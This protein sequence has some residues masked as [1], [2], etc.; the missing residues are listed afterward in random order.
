[1]EVDF[2]QKYNKRYVCNLLPDSTRFRIF[3][4]GMKEYRSNFPSLEQGCTKFGTICMGQPIQLQYVNVVLESLFEDRFEIYN[5]FLISLYD[6]TKVLICT[7]RT[8]WKCWLG[9]RVYF[10]FQAHV[11]ASERINS[12]K[13]YNIMVLYKINR[14]C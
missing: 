5:Q 7:I 11:K 8:L 4:F 9:C 14:L 2:E 13:Y 1:M 3:V 6:C 10:R 12:I